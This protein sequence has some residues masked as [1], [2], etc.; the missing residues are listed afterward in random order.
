MKCQRTE[1]SVVAEHFH[2]ARA[3]GQLKGSQEEEDTNNQE[4]EIS[5]ARNNFNSERTY[6]LRKLW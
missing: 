4:I 2:S 5:K 6:N 3:C 1:T